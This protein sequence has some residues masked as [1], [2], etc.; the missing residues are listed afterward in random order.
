MSLARVVTFE[1]VGA[2]RIAEMREGMQGDP[3]EGLPASEIVL[4]YDESASKA[5]AI[6]FFDDDES[7][8]AGDK[9]LDA[10]P[11][12]DTTGRRT[13]VTKYEVAVRRST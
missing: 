2:D 4:L 8:A 5:T 6:V 9:V 10:M 1:G 11:T 13:S 7:Y 12:G 3:P